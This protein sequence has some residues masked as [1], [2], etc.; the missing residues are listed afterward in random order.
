M[1]RLSV[2]VEINLEEIYK[3]TGFIRL[4]YEDIKPILYNAKSVYVG[5]GYGA[6][7]NKGA[8]AAGVALS[9]PVINMPLDE[10]TGVII[11]FTGGYDLNLDDIEEACIFVMEKLQ[12]EIKPII[13]AAFDENMEEEEL[14]VTLI[15]IK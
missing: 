10:A 8:K 9:N 15:A 14:W 6:G 1:S 5:T 4:D 13:S 2:N 11:T 7:L 3:E 12:P